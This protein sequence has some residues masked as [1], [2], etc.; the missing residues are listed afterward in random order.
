M[1]KQY[2]TARRLIEV[3]ASL[4]KVAQPDDGLTPAPQSLPMV[5]PLSLKYVGPS[6]KITEVETNLK[7]ATSESLGQGQDDEFLNDLEVMTRHEC[8]SHEECVQTLALFCEA[9]PYFIL[10]DFCLEDKSGK[11]YPIPQQGEQLELDL[12]NF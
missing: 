7:A 8:S 9:Y 11:S 3:T 2:E 12:S 5:P 6:S 1:D 10:E 4:R